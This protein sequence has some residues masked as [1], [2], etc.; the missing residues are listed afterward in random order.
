MQEDRFEVKRTFVRFCCFECQC[1][2]QVVK[3]TDGT[4]IISCPKCGTKKEVGKQKHE[5][6]QI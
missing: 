6:L 3:A 1:D 5:S 2:M 4:I